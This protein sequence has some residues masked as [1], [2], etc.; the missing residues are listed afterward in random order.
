M[1]VPYVDLAASYRSLKAE[2]DAA[3]AGVLASGDYVLGGNVAAFEEEFDG[4]LGAAG[5]EVVAVNSGTDAIYLTLKVLGVG[6]GDEVITVSHTAVNTALA[7]SKAGASPVFVDIEPRTFCMDPSLLEGAISEKT[8]AVVPV[9][10]Y[11]HP[12]D[13]DP[14]ME[15]AARHGL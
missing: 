8:R 4:W 9:H 3:V 7:I 5:A 12:V 1:D 2:V 13:M 11:G 14:V 15:V 6:P 10:L